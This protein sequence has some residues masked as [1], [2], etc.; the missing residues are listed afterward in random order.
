MILVFFC[1]RGLISILDDIADMAQKS[2]FLKENPKIL[3][4]NNFQ[5]PPIFSV[6]FET[7]KEPFS[8]CPWNMADQKN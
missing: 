1:D 6:K 4:I 3:V 5:C 7:A 8:R 2:F